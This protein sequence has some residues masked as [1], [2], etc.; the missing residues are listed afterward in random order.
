MH[1][2]EFVHSRIQEGKIDEI[3]DL[4]K[5]YLDH[6]FEIKPPRYSSSYI[7]ARTFIFTIRKALKHVG[8]DDK[9][10]DI[11]VLRV[12]ADLGFFGINRED[13]HDAQ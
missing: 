6:L 5:R 4:L 2:S 7:F 9:F 12:W 3:S 11:K 10:D 1:P 8:P 13:I